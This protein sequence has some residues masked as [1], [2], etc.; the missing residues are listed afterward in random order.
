MFTPGK[1]QNNPPNLNETAG[2]AVLPPAVESLITPNLRG[3]IWP[4]EI[5]NNNELIAQSELRR[6]LS[7]TLDATYKNIPR[8]TTSIHNAIE[9]GSIKEETAKK[10]YDDLVQFLESDELAKRLVLY[11]PFELLPEKDATFSSEGLNQSVRKFTELYITKW[12]ELLH[13]IDFRANFVDGDIPEF[14]V[15]KSPLPK[16]SKAAHLIPILVQKKFLKTEEVLDIVEKSS[17]DTINESVAD[18]LTVLADMQLLSEK[19]LERMEKSQN[20]LL[21]NMSVIIKDNMHASLTEDTSQKNLDRDV[22]EKLHANI[23][24][25]LSNL[26][27]KDWETLPEARA[28]WKKEQS[29]KKILSNYANQIFKALQAKSI[30]VEDMKKYMETTKDTHSTVAGILGVRKVIESLEASNPENAKELERAFEPMLLELWKDN[31]PEIREII[32]STWVR[33][34]SLGLINETFLKEQ[35]VALSKIDAPF[36]AEEKGLAQ[37]LKELA[38]ITKSIEQNQELSKLVYPV[39]IMY[40]S[41][42]KGYGAHNADIDIAV[43]TKPRTSMD[44]QARIEKLLSETFSHEKVKGKTLQFWLEEN[45]NEMKIQDLVIPNKPLGNSAQTHVLFEGAWCG[46]E[47]AIKELYEKLLPGY[48]Y[49]KDKKV[50]DKDAREIWLGEMERDML[51]YRLMHKGYARSYPEQGG[52]KTPHSD[53]IDSESAFWDSGYRRIATK[54]FITKVFLPQLEKPGK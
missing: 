15:M 37:E 38:G 17:D 48:L 13:D 3:S 22:L 24:K 8:A 14:E 11:F 21:R 26:N 43:F 2:L 18:G 52:I 36:N 7:S 49:S 39:S 32:K 30:S 47:K 50:I 35:G 5:K 53:A 40:G 19:D 6:N 10:L 33:W 51:Q 34:A 12:R 42:I 23:E 46:D 25:D 27:L 20:S 16:V 28:A 54:L 29:E 31:N 9:S 41:K 4:E 44:D 45:E 1:S